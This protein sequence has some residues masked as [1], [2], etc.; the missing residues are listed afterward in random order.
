MNIV[1]V[2]LGLFGSTGKIMLG[3]EKATASGNRHCKVYPELKQNLPPGKNDILITGVLSRKINHCLEKVTGY[4]GCFSFIRTLRIIRKIDAFHPDIIHL[5]NLH[6]TII[7]HSMLFH[8]IKKNNIKTI[9]TLHD[10]WAFTA[11]CPHFVIARCEKWKKGCHNCPQYK[12]YPS[13]FVDRTKQMWLLKRKWFTNVPN[14]IIV[15]P[16]L[17]LSGLVKKSYLKDYE[18]RVINNGIDLSIFK[19]T[20]GTFRKKYQI[21]NDRVVLLGVAFGW[22]KKKGLDVFVDLAKRLDQR[23]QI[24]L[25]GTTDEID[26]QLPSNIIS[27]HRTNNQKE[28][29][30]I[31]SAADLFLNPTREE[32]YPTVNMEAIACGTPVITFD[33]GG[34]PEMLN[35]KCGV[36]IKSNSVDEMLEKI[37]DV[38]MT[39]QFDRKECV[40][41][42]KGFDMHDRFRDYSALYHSMV[43]RK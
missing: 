16:S 42:A 31:Y 9:W 18:V 32:N 24:V 22:G 1:Q 21:S 11:Q 29:A 5:H 39:H 37:I 40:K 36:V 12:D 17:W 34:S 2:N 43:S 41:I 28:L 8:Y 13:A 23:F 3:I 4:Q 20:E 7:N 27:I 6:G 15:T 35:E 33:T 10:C 14:M 26:K 19:P 38:T 25:V 30:E